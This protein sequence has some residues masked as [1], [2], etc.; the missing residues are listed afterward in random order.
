M[1]LFQHHFLNWL[2]CYSEDDDGDDAADDDG[3][4]GHEV[5]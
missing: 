1:K 3:D 2:A 4:G 5:F